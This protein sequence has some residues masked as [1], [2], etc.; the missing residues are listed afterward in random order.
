MRGVYNKKISRFAKLHDLVSLRIS[1][2]AI[3]SQ[4]PLEYMIQLQEIIKLQKAALRKVHNI[5][6]T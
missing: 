2:R 5:S 4:I 3:D 6:K 1:R